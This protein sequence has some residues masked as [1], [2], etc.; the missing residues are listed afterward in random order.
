LNRNDIIR[1][2]QGEERDTRM[3]SPFRPLTFA[4]VAAAFWLAQPA[5]GASDAAL[6]SKTIMFVCLHGAANSQVA[7]AHFNRIASERGLPYTAIS[8]GIDVV[9]SVPTRIRD[10]LSLDGL[11]PTNPRPLTAAE[12]ATVATVVAFDPVPDDQ[13]GLVKV[14][15][16]SDV[17]LAMSDYEASRDA[18]VRHIDDLVPA[19]A[20]RAQAQETLQGVVAAVDERND[21]IAVRLTSDRTEDFRVQDGLIFNAVRDGDRVELT[22]ETVDGT[23]TI[24]GLKKE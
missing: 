6:D 5:F 9:P 10:G 11:E 2:G 24:V 8:R 22:V 17:P 23:R 21:R 12:A 16:W 13:R 7:A 18:I 3:K 15:Y 1:K 14:S 20:T 19:L 4:V